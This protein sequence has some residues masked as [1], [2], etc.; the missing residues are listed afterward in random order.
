VQPNS[1]TNW[2]L[3]LR[4]V[5]K[6]GGKNAPKFIPSSNYHKE[7]KTIKFIKAHYPSNPKHSFNPK[8]EVR[9]EIPKMREEAFVC[10]FYSRAGHLDEFFFCRKRIEK[11][12]FDYTRNSY[13]DEFIDFPPHSYSRALPRTSSR[14]LSRFSHG[15][16]HRS[17]GFGSQE[18]NF[19][20]RCFG[21]DPR[22]HRGDR[23]SRRS[24]F[25]AGGSYTHFEPRYLDDP[26]FL[27]RG[28]RPTGSKTEVQKRV[29]TYSGRMVKCWIP[30][31]YLT[32]PSTEPLTSSHP[33]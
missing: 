11:R 6:K 28:S 1:D 15:P 9:K 17:Y 14:A 18:N 16:N 31:I 22:S 19:V 32:N 5:R 26:R 33:M 10:M 24:H 23:F 21:Y 2:V 12:R 7:E 27:Y 4:D 8:R 29:K 13:R 25:S 20:P 30:K 3:D